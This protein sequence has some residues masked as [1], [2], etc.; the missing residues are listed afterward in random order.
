[1]IN[2]LIP[3]LLYLTIELKKHE[4]KMKHH[5]LLNQFFQKK[6]SK[7]YKY[8]ISGNLFFKE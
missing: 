6:Y 7:Y 3:F 8:R 5:L 4:A 2:I 1:M